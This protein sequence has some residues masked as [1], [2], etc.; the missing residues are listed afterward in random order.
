MAGVP[1]MC[2]VY[3]ER[4]EELTAAADSKQQTANSLS[5]LN[6]QRP[7]HNASARGAS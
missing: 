6:A 7:M 2:E 5:V 4:L 1:D 3:A